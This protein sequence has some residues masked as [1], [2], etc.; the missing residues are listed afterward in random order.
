MVMISYKRR[1]GAGRSTPQ[2][3]TASAAPRRTNTSLA[4]AL[5][6]KDHGLYGNSPRFKQA[7]AQMQ[8]DLDAVAETREA[9]IS[10]PDPPSEA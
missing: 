5:A 2:T 8:A 6:A 7:L 1:A 10:R 3:V 4:L 9:E